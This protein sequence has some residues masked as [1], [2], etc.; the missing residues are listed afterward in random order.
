MVSTI[1]KED[2]IAVAEGIMIPLTEAQINQVLD[3]YNFEEECDPTASWNLI[4]EHCINQV[5]N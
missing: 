2:V 1:S 4:V 5:I 3:L